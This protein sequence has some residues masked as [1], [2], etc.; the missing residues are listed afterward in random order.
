MTAHTANARYAARP[1]AS[2]EAP[3]PPGAGPVAATDALVL[4]VRD[5]RRAAH[6]YRDAL[7]M[8]CTAYTGP[9]TGNPHLCSYVL[10]AGGARWVLSSA[11]GARGRLARHLADHGEGVLEVALRVPDV[12]WAFDYA[13][14]RGA[15]AVTE[16]YEL[17]DRH[18]TVVLA[19]IGTGGPVRHTLVDRTGYTGPYLPGYV[20]PPAA[21]RTPGQPDGQGV[22]GRRSGRPADGRS[23]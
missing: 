12:H 18:G 15:L 7:G 3:P 6:H 19:A 13:V 4:A 2:P 14:D 11:T 1:C 20:A 22:S 16:P 10:E 23:R 8:H 21:L 9:E 5:A 17:S